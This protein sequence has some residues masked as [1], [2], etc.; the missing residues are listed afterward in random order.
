[1]WRKL[2]KKWVEYLSTQPESGM[3]FQAVIVT[4]KSGDTFPTVVMGGDQIKLEIPVKHISSIKL[5]SAFQR[6]KLVW[7]AFK[8]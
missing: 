7:N 5:D 3:G 1:M 6:W 8:K 2:P 4:L